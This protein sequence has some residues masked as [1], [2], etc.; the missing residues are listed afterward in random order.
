MDRRPEP[1]VRTP[2]NVVDSESVGVIHVIGPSDCKGKNK[3]TTEDVLSV[4][5]EPWTSKR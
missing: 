3:R 4:E 1:K 2:K 5:Q